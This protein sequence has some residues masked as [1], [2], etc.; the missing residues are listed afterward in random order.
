MGFLELL[1][2]LLCPAVL[3]ISVFGVKLPDISGAR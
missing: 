1:K 3:E 2:A